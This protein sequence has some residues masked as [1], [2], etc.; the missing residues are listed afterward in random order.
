MIKA[1]AWLRILWQTPLIM[2]GVVYA[3]IAVPMQ[4][5]LML[6]GYSHSQLATVVLVATLVLT[7]QL[8][9]RQAWPVD[10][11]TPARVLVLVALCLASGFAPAGWRNGVDEIRRWGLALLVGYLVYVVPR[12]WQD[13]AVLVVVLILAPLGESVFALVQSMRGIG[14]A[15]FQIAN[16]SFTRAFGT[17]GQPNS[18]AGYLNGAWPLVLCFTIVAWQQRSRWFWLMLGI[19]GLIGT[20]LLLS[21]SRGAWIGAIAGVLVILWLVGGWWRRG[22]AV[23]V[24]VAA[25][26][27]AGGWQYV[28]A[29]FGPRL[30]SATQIFSAPDILRDEAQQRPTVYAAVERAAQFKAGVAMWQSAPLL[31]IGPG[32]YTRVYPEFARMGWLIS[33]G[34]AHNAY[35]QIAA[36]QGIVGLLAFLGLWAMQWRRA[37]RTTQVAG[38]ARWVAIAAC[39]TMAAVAVHECFEYLQVNYLPLH[40]AAVVALAGVAMRF[41]PT[42]REE[43]L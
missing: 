12:R 25:F 10:E 34:H 26:V 14:P 41:A 19:L 38:M 30:G 2:W 24:V 1:S 22:V 42:V 17:I 37:W 29:P 33:R 43:Q 36:E 6:A 9:R 40:T 7:W 23:I 31:G 35:V 15:A 8:R 20:A 4:D 11:T 5:Y 27:L 21:F 3:I 32:S 18:F 28:P 39:G 13:V 16:S